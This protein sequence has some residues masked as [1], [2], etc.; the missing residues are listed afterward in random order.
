[1]LVTHRA[2]G[3]PY[4][5]FAAASLA[6]LFRALIV[7]YI[8]NSYFPSIPPWLLAGSLVVLGPAHPMLWILSGPSV[9]E[10]AIV[11][12]QTFLLAG[13]FFALPA[14]DGSDRSAWRLALVGGL[15][16]LALGSRLA[17]VGTVAVLAFSIVVALVRE[18]Q[19]RY[20]RKAAAIYASTF[21]LPPAIGVGLL[22]LYNYARFGNFLETGYQFVLSGVDFN[23][24]AEKGQV[25]N[26]AYLAPNLLYYAVTPV[27]PIS[28]FPLIKR[29]VGIGP[30]SPCS[31][32]GLKSRNLTR[33][34]TL[35]ACSLPYP[36]SYSPAF[37][38][39]VWP[40]GRCQTMQQ[41]GRAQSLANWIVRGDSAGLRS[42]FF[43]RL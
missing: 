3:D 12:G 23:H 1:M 41:M 25:F 10:A 28:L 40:V 5:V 37:L 38:S 33:L 6:F 35:Q 9:L 32:D 8:R 7:L 22:G 17:L 11:S 16:A 20:S 21:V 34:R 26:V 15:W 24:L 31:W 18:E 29:Y 14:I 30:H 36:S 19:G 27:R 39:R 42:F 2:V 43:S 4:I 13:L